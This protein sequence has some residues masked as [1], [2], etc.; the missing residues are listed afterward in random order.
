MS[1]YTGWGPGDI[2]AAAMDREE[3]EEIARKRRLHEDGEDCGD[4][5]CDVCA[6]MRE[7]EDEDEEDTDGRDDE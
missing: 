7:T 1:V 4:E 5:E 6:E 3:R 2:Y